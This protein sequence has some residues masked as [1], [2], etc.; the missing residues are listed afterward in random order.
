MHFLMDPEMIWEWL[1]PMV[2]FFMMGVV[3]LFLVYVFVRGKRKKR[4]PS[5]PSE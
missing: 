4:S 3:L 5:S 1:G 2:G